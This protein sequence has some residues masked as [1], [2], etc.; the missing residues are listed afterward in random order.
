M[1]PGNDDNQKYTETDR[2]HRLDILEGRATP[3]EKLDKREQMAS[4]NPRVDWKYTKPLPKVD[5]N[6]DGGY[7]RNQ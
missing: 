4:T 7:T 5:F 6:P 3:N 2:K 1:R